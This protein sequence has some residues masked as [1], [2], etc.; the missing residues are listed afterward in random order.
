MNAAEI[1]DLFLRL[2][3]Y[4]RF[5]SFRLMQ[6]EGRIAQTRYPITESDILKISCNILVGPWLVSIRC[7]NYIHVW[8]TICTATISLQAM[9]RVLHCGRLG[10][11]LYFYAC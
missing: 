6:P 3:F 9:E 2:F 10:V 8:P 1:F 7:G 5:F 4:L 11:V